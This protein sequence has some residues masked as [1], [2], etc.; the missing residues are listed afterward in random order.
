MHSVEKR[1]YLYSLRKNDWMI[2]VSK[3]FGNSCS[4]CFWFLITKPRPS[5]SHCT[6]WLPASVSLFSMLYSCVEN[7][8]ALLGSTFWSE[9]LRCCACLETSKSALTVWVD[10][11]LQSSLTP[12]R[13]EAR[14]DV[15]S[16]LVNVPRSSISACEESLLESSASLSW[17]LFARSNWQWSESSA[18]DFSSGML[19]EL[20][21]DDGLY[22]ISAGGRCCEHLP[23]VYMEAVF[24]FYMQAYPSNLNLLQVRFSGSV[25]AV[26]TFF[27][28]PT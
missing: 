7:G 17:P 24:H 25:A 26:V 16:S 1:S 10:G 2:Q 13:D 15:L 22:R 4:N 8:L 9:A 3:Y 19:L 20:N 12:C 27:R 11:W 6:A 5:C 28:V 21:M 23:P 14:D 18:P